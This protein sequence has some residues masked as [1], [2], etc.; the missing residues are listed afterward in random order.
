MQNIFIL[1]SLLSVSFACRTERLPVSLGTDRDSHRIDSL[2][3]STSIEALAGLPR[4]SRLASDSRAE[5]AERAIWEIR[6]G[7][8]QFRQDPDGGYHVTIEDGQGHSMIVEIPAPI[9]MKGSRFL[10]TVREVRKHFGERF[11]GN[12]K[13]R[14]RMPETPV[15]VILHGVGFFDGP[16]RQAGAAANGI[17][18]NPVTLICFEDESCA[19]I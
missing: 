5:A 17:E 13:R 7:I 15:Q 10:K 4:P 1:A 6:A 2:P 9:C 11:P 8:K 18:L 3:Q 12:P 14:T 19:G 16:H